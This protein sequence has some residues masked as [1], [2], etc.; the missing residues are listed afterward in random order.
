MFQIRRG[1][2]MSVFAACAPQISAMESRVRWIA[3]SCPKTADY[4]R[5]VSLRRARRET[6][7]A[8]AGVVSRYTVCRGETNWCRDDLAQHG[9]FSRRCFCAPHSGSAKAQAEPSAEAI[10]RGKA[11]DD[12]GRLH[13]LPYRRSGKAVR[14]RQAHRYPLRRDLFGQSDAGPRNRTW[15]L[16]RRRFL[17]RA[18]LRRGRLTAR[19]IIRPSPIRIS[20]SSPAT[21]CWRSG[22]ISRR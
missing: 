22:P 6:T 13:E 5:F 12:R 4:F 18:A 19:A 15:G 7:R 3:I 20:R 16:E 2:S 14:R 8:P 9:R 11:L 17:R 1:Q 21:T 10:A